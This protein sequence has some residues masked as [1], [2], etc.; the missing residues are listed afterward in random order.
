MHGSYCYKQNDNFMDKNHK[1][2]TGM[3]IVLFLVG[4]SYFI[5]YAQCKQEI[6]P[7]TKIGYFG[8]TVVF[9]V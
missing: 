9:A 2:S 3:M 5:W 1:L 4:V 7:N 8:M 6:V